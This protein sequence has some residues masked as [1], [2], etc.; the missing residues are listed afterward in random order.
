MSNYSLSEMSQKKSS[1]YLLSNINPKNDYYLVIM[2]LDSKKKT[3]KIQKIIAESHKYL[4]SD[5]DKINFK[6]Y[7]KINIEILFLK[8]Q[9]ETHTFSVDL[10]N[11][12]IIHHDDKVY[13]EIS[14]NNGFL[15]CYFNFDGEQIF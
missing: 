14:N 9:K 15:N 8:K 5:N 13:V 2:S 12:L 1:K 6:K 3:K 7:Y 11:N 4:I 10:N